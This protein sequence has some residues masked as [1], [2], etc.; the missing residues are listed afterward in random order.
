MDWLP[1][2]VIA[3]ALGFTFLNGYNGSASIVATVVASGAVSRRRALAL[4]AAGELIGPLVLG[5]AVAE[6][7]A[8]DVVPPGDATGVALACGLVAAI[9]WGVIASWRG[10]PMSS[11]H[12]L[13]GGLAGA[14]LAARGLAGVRPEGLLGVLIALIATPTIALVGGYVYMKLVLRAGQHFTPAINVYL[15]RAQVVTSALVAAAHGANEAQKGMGLIAAALVIRDGGAISVP[16]W[17]Q[18]ACACAIAGGVAVGGT[19][20]LRTL[21][22]RVYRIRPVHGFAVQVTAAAIIL[23]SSL[24]GGPTSTNQ[25]AT[26][27]IFGVGAAERATQVR[28]E[29]G[30]SI[31]VA[32]LVTAPAAALGGATLY[33]IVAGLARL[34]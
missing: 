34:A 18:V 32:W 12:A 15:R 28:W 23:I 1:T 30:W 29:L 10:L 27:A 8:R 31:A 19:A 17:A 6:T 24:L 11:T 9:G 3:L 22:A 4:A 33:L 13:V 25:V 20:T 26:S 14:G 7:I 5:V 16:L 21:G 2:L